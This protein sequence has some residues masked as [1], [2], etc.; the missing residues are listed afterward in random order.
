MT[1]TGFVS[2]AEESHAC[3][4]PIYYDSLHDIETTWAAYI[5]PEIWFT[6]IRKTLMG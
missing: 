1:I 6:C 3:Y 2:R 4:L 5:R